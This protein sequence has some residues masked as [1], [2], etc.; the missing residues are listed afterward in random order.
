VLLRYRW[1]KL[2]RAW[3]T[4]VLGE[5]F[6]AT[7]TRSAFKWLVN[8]ENGPREL[9][10]AFV[11]RMFDDL[12]RGTKRAILKLYRA[13]GDPAER[14]ARLAAIFREDPTPALV[15]WGAHDPYIGVEHAERQRE[16]FGQAE[17]RILPEAG[18]WPFADDP[19]GVESA[20][21]PFLRAQ[22][23]APAAASVQEAASAHGPGG[24]PGVS[25]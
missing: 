22:L 13:T 7:T 2:A 25:R 12:D 18:H 15:V 5:L 10:D 17:V 9:P 20:V 24:L 4:P 14:S 3:R 19:G 1:H 6:T 16:A 8:R 11:D 21:L 23:G